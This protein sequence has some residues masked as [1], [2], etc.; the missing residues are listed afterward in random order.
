MN[1]QQDAFVSPP[2]PSLRAPVV[3]VH[4]LSGF[5]RVFRT[6][7]PSQ[8]FFPGVRSHLEMAG[9][10][11]LMPRVSA[12][13][14]IATR[15]GELKAFIRREVGTA[16]VHII[17]HSMGGL[18]ARY[19]VSRLG[20]DSQVLSLTTIG[21]P[22]R[23]TA[24]ADW[25]VR[26]FGRLTHPLFRAMGISDDAFYDLTTESCGRFNAD[27]PNVPGVRYFSVA[28]VIERPWLAHGW[29]LPCGI[30]RKAEGPN[31]GVVSVA[32]ATWGE[33]T[34]IWQGDHLNL[35]NWPNKRMR[36]AGEW[37]D[38][39]GE[40]AALLGQLQQAGF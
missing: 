22:H 33:S 6:K 3:L 34:A 10:R 30:V 36:K 27:T 19:A 32:S 28:G 24:F 13:A 15:A 17:G 14:S 25:G 4:G 37:P 9:N 16:K 18:D 1:S 21:C 40:Y 29:K 20:L 39:T 38:R 26:M 11:V 23:G 2:V 8:E 35:V 5:D 12:T 31:D 7:R